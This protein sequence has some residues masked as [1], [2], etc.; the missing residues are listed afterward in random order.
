M[1][2]P[3]SYKIS[4]NKNQAYKQLGNSVVVD[5][6]Q[7][8]TYQIALSLIQVNKTVIPDTGLVQTSTNHLLSAS[9]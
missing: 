6:L 3:D 8:I 5:V 2:F 4:E 9:V 1:G 7:L